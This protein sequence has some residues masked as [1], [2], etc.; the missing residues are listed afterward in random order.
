MGIIIITLIAIT[1]VIVLWFISIYNSLI[2]LRNRSDESWSDID[3][4][5][6]RRH[7]LVP[8]LVET[9]KGYAAHER[10]TF[11]EVTKARSQA[12]GATT[13]Q[14]RGQTEN[15][16]TSALKSLFAVSERYP[17]LKA[18]QNFLDLQ[19]SL[20]E[21][22]DKIQLSRRYYNAVVRDLNNKIQM[23]PSNLVAR[24]Y[25]FELKEFFEIEEGAREV[26]EV[27]F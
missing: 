26:P 15:M 23:F 3:V 5:L 25:A 21:I 19:S 22:E 18:N 7:D 16:L 14:Q 9:V 8:N 6:K 20:R 24:M 4:Q 11:E 2:N 13:P 1:A 10:G 12:M 27:K 17:E